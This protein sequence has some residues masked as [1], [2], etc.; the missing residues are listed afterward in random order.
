MFEPRVTLVIFEGGQAKTELDS[1][2]ASVRREV[3]LDTCEKLQSVEEIDETIL[4]TNYPDLAE[5]A[6][7]MGVTVDY[8]PPGSR[9]FHFGKRLRE[10][11][12][13]H[14]IENVIYMGGAA[15]PLITAREFSDI[16]VALKRERN[17][18]VMN[19]VQSADLVAF[20][21]ARA[22]DEIELPNKDNP[23]GN[24]L[25]EIG[26]RRVLIPNSGRV[27]FDL[28]TPTDF[29]VLGMHPMCGPRAKRAIDALDW[30]RTTIE[31]AVGVLRQS[32][33]EVAVVG[34]VGPAVIQYVNSNMV[35]R[36]R[37]FSEERGMKALGREE[38]GEVVSLL[39][40]M[41]EEVGPERFF[42]Y[43]AKTVD[44]AFIDSRVIFAHLRKQLSDWDRFQ[45]DLGRYELIEDPWTREFTRCACTAR[46]P[47]VLGGH[48]LVAAGLWLMA[49]MIVKEREASGYRHNTYSLSR[50]IRP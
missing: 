27:N 10:V 22:I 15:A 12:V 38:R 35:H 41:V 31:S 34:R 18:V 5:A 11:I 20:A 21:P 32:S 25:R 33:K 30:P 23:L 7:E 26:M 16:A 3:V 28:D 2:I 13:T 44:V 49:E 24:L 45:S 17:L 47:I 36:M 14:G 29:L 46:V 4:V 19:N 48:S 39:G 9:P 50:G 37:V 40:F 6:R 8:E 43:L 42:D 1:L